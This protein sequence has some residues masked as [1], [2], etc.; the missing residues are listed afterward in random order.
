MAS[1]KKTP[2]VIHFHNAYRAGKHYDLRLKYTDK[3]MLISFAVPIDKF[4]IKKGEKGLAIQTPDHGVGWLY[5]EK[6]EIPRG[7]YGGGFIERKQYG[8]AKIIAWK[9]NY[10]EFEI[11]GDFATGVYFLFKLGKKKGKNEIWIFYKKV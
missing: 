8:D 2:Y 7:Q 6:L 10:I 3:K 9:S 5:R 4:P 11:K 1:T